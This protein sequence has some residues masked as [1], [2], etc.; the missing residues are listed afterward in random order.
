MFDPERMALVPCVELSLA[1]MRLSCEQFW[2]LAT[3]FLAYLL[4]REPP[5]PARAVIFMNSVISQGI[6]TV[7]LGRV[8]N[9]EGY[10]LWFPCSDVE[11]RHLSTVSRM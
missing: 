10:G 5:A 7:S 4:F 11:L 1:L 3:I 9:C 8:H 2:V 6:Q